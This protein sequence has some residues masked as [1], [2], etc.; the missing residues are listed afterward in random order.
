MSTSSTYQSEVISMF[1]VSI[2]TSFYDEIKIEDAW[3]LISEIALA[4]FS[5]GA[6][7]M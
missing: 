1:L 5:V 3:A 6:I 7:S 2:P 4:F